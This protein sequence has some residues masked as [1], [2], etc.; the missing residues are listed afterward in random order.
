MVVRKP[1][2]YHRFRRVAIG[3]VVFPEDQWVSHQTQSNHQNKSNCEESHT[4]R[5][6]GL[7]LFSLD[8]ARLCVPQKIPTICG[9]A[10]GVATSAIVVRQ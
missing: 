10:N 2:D 9:G 6:A 3:L 5:L 4:D 7:R 8:A 1:T